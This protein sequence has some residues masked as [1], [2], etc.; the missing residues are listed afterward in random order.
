MA[1]TLHWEARAEGRDGML[2]VGWV[3]LNRLADPRFPVT[4]CEVVRQGGERPGCQFS[5][6]CD[7]RG[8]VPRPSASW[9]LAQA[10]AVELL[11]APPLDPTNGALFYHSTRIAMPWAFAPERTVRIGRHVFYR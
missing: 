10:V 11:E 8:D 9:D 3:V 7:G 2:A 6:W 1:Q 5:Y 4:V